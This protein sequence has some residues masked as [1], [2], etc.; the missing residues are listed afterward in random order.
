MALLWAW[1]T[2]TAA[3]LEL[4]IAV[5]IT[6]SITGYVTYVAGYLAGERS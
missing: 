2:Y 4:P 5:V 1:L 3:A 6:T